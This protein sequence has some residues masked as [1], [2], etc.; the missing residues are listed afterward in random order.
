MSRQIGNGT[1]VFLALFL[2]IVQGCSAG[3]GAIRVGPVGVGAGRE[4]RAASGTPRDSLVILHTNDTH[5]QILPFERSNGALVGGAAARA[6]LV[7]RERER[8]RRTVLLDAGDVFQGTPFFALFGG[9][10]DYRAMSMMGYQAGALGN[11]DLDN[12]PAAWIRTSREAK[13]AIR[14]ANVFVAA[15]SSWAR[16]RVEVPAAIR[17]GAKWIGGAKV[18][19]PAPLVFLTEKPWEVERLGP[20]GRVATFGLTT[21]D[22]VRIVKPSRNGGVAVADPIAAAR[23]LVPKLREKASLVV[24]LSHLGDDM[25]RKLAER[26]SGIDVIVGGHNHKAIH[27]PVLVRNA[28]PNG[29]GGTLIVQA[30]SRG[31]YLGRLVLYLDGDRAVRYAGALLRVR[32]ADGEDAK[33]A[34]ILRPYAEKVEAETGGV[35]FHSPARYPNTGLRDGET[36]L[37]NFVADVIRWAGNADVGFVNSGGIRAPMP[38][39]DVTEADIH[40]IVPFDN[41]IVVV[42]MPGYLLRQLLDRVAR[43]IGKGGFLQVS[44]LKFVISRDR[45]SYIRVGGDPLD[46]E[47]EYRVATI[48]YLAEGGDGYTQFAKAR[49]LE[50]TDALLRDEAVRFL[51][52]HPEYELKKETRIRWE[53]STATFR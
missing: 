32:P 40:S 41:Q 46:P 27:Q 14:S 8:D 19:D 49:G 21:P 50:S 30:G 1:A 17:R 28:T 42:R 3:A 5:A 47:R 34:A 53:G 16:G 26:V 4:P 37:G 22:L 25:D 9:V 6:D 38:E 45:A 48:D 15:E 7:R 24:C 20:V 51:R 31:E 29:Y 12:G 35:V 52:E 43:R 13:F 23:Y 39:G 44:G 18:P 36:P 11:H 2:A 10:P 33:V